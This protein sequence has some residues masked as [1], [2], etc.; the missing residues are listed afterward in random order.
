MLVHQTLGTVEQRARRTLRPGW[1][2]SGLTSSEMHFSIFIFTWERSIFFNL[3]KSLS[4]FFCYMQPC[5]NTNDIYTQEI[6][7]NSN[8]WSVMWS[9]S[10]VSQSAKVGKVY[11][12]RE[13]YCVFILISLLW[14]LE[15]ADED[16]FAL[17]VFGYFL[18]EQ[19]P[20]LGRL[21]NS[22]NC[23]I[24]LMCARVMPIST[25]RTWAYYSI[26]QKSLVVNENG[27]WYL[28][29]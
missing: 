6:L 5:L 25:G 24:I 20:S 7:R 26:S 19:M 11:L 27:L 2:Q 10:Q 21:L 15:C 9:G 23:I 17:C 12:R 8:T 1:F 22:V 16:I 14:I 4:E 3:F 28:Q 29:I 18:K 13:K